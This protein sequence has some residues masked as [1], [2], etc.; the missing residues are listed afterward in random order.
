MCKDHHTKMMF[1][2]V[3]ERKGALNTWVIEKIKEDIARLGYQDVV[4]KVDGEAALVQ[5]LKN[6]K[7]CLRNTLHNPA[8]T[9]V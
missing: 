9:S 1:G 8:L 6:V 5:V 4:L 7:T 2:H 3:C